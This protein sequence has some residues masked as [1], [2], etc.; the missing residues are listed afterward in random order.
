MGEKM[1]EEKMEW[2]ERMA[3]MQ[4]EHRNRWCKC[5]LQSLQNPK[6]MTT[7]KSMWSANETKKLPNHEEENK[8]SEEQLKTVVDKSMEKSELQTLKSLNECLS[9]EKVEIEK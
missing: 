8:D 2:R 9:K 4:I 5:K 7:K 1:E 6:T 3:E